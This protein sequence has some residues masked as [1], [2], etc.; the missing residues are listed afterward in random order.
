MYER[1]NFER[2]KHHDPKIC[3]RPM[4]ENFDRST[5]LW[6]TI[7]SLDSS[8]RSWLGSCFFIRSCTRHNFTSSTEAVRVRCNHSDRSALLELAL[9]SHCL[10]SDAVTPLEFDLIVRNSRM[11]HFCGDTDA[12]SQHRQ[13]S[14]FSFLWQSPSSSCFD[15]CSFLLE[16]CQFTCGAVH[17]VHHAAATRSSLNQHSFVV[18][19]DD[20]SRMCWKGMGLRFFKGIVIRLHSGWYRDHGSIE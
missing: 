11:Q 3:S 9:R 10:L 13:V 7:D 12:L 1:L 8:T 20:T 18:S 15:F 14:G 5:C 17:S 6:L 2:K 4:F 19:D 16:R